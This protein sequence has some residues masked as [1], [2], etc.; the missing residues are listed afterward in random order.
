MTAGAVFALYIGGARDYVLILIG[1]TDYIRA[2]FG[3]EG[4]TYFTDYPLVLRG[5]WTLNILGGLT[6][7]LLLVARRRWAFPVAVIAAAAQIVLLVV[8]FVFL[9]RW[10]SLGAPIAWFDIGIGVVTVLFAIYCWAMG[11]RGDVGA[12]VVCW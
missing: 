4:V 12:A 5:V 3:A 1:D 2:Q 6:A 10:A 9:D 11:S 8:T 7:P